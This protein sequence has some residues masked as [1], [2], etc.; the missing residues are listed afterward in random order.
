MDKKSSLVNAHGDVA[1]LYSR[2]ERK[3]FSCGLFKKEF[4]IIPPQ[5]L[6]IWKCSSAVIA[7]RDTPVASKF[8]QLLQDVNH[9][10]GLTPSCSAWK[11]GTSRTGA[12]LVRDT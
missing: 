8:Q 3:S 4:S 12:I 1:V 6:S 10:T 11:N 5:F 2:W 7:T 9:S